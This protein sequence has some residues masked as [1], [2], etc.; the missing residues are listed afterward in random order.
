MPGSFVYA[1]A[2]GTVL[3]A[4]T[5]TLGVT[6][7]P[8]DTTLYTTATASTT[9]VVN[10]PRTTPTVSWATPAAITQGTAL[11][12]T[13]LNAT[14]SVPGSFVYAPAAGTVLTA[15]THTLGVTF[16]PTDTTRYT[17]A[18]AST[19]LVVNVPRTT[20]TVSWA[21]PAAITQGTALGA[22]QLNATASVPGSF[23]YAPAA[24]TVLT[25]GTHTLG[26]TFTPTDTTRYTTATASTTL[27]VN[28]P[29]TTPT[30][31]WATP[32]AI[33]QGT[34][35][36]A[37][38]LNATASVP[39]SFVYAPAAGTV[40]A[41]GT[42]TLGVTFTPTDAT[43]YTTATA[44]TTL[45]VNVPRTTP[46]V[47][48]A[49][50]AAI[51]QGTALSATQ[52][53]ATASVPG[54][55]VYA[56]AAGTVLTAG[57]HT[58]G[59]TFTPTDATRY[60]TATASTALVVNVPRTTPVLTWP[61]PASITQGTAL[62]A[63]Q[64]NATASVPGTFV[65]A[66]AAGTVL[67]AGTHT[68]GV[69]FTP[70]DATLYTTATASTTLV[71]TV[72]RTTPV[73][74]WPAPASITQGTA[75][76][77]TQLNATASV[78][79]TFVYAPAAGTVLAAGTHT[80]GVTFTPTDTTRY[81]AATASTTLVVTVPRTTPT[82]S[83]ATPAAITQGTALGAAQLNAT[84]S[85]PGSF[86]YAPA[87]GTVLA[88]GTHTLGVTFTPTDTTRY[89]TATASTTLVVNVPRT[90]PT[91]SWAT[92]AAITQ[93]TALGATQLNATASVPGT[94]VYAPAAGT[95][96]TAGTHTLGV[97]F[98]PTDTTLYT[99]ATASTTLVVNVPRTTPTVSWATPAAITQGTALGAAQLNATASVPGSFVY[100]P[101]AGTV[102]AAGTHTLGVTFTPTDA[103]RYT[104]ATASTTLVVNVP[105][106][107]PVLTWP[108]PVSITAGTPLSAT[109]L[110]A[111]ASVPGI[112]VYAPAAG[113]VLAAGTH[114]LG[115]TFT[116]TDA[117]RYTTA[118][119]STTLVV[120]VPRTT[121]VLT[122]PAPV[123]ITAGTPLS[124]T[125]LN[126][127]ASVPGSFVYAPAAGT[128]LPE[129][130]HTLQ[131]NF[132]PADATLYT[133]ATAST[134]L[135]VTAPRTTPTMWWRTPAAI[136]QGTALGATQLNATASVPGTFVYT[137]AAGT[138]LPAG[139]HT[140]RAAFTPANTTRYTTATAV[141]ALVVTVPR[142]TPTVSWATPA[143][144][145][146]GTALSA[147]QLNATA[148]VPGT[149]VYAP[150][151]GTVLAAGTHTLGVT[152]TPTDATLYT[153]ATA[154]T[155]LVVNVPRTTPTVSWA[156]PA[157]ITQGTALSATQLN[158]T[159]SVPGIFVYAPAAGTV[160][161][162]GTQTLAPRRHAHARGHLHADRHD[163]LHD[164]D[165]L[166]HPGGQ[167]AAHDADA[168]LGDAS[169]HHAGHR[170]QRDATERHGQRRRHLRLRARRRDRPRRRH[171]HARG[172]V[173]ADGHDAVHRGDRLDHAGGHR[174]AHHADGVVGD[175]GRH[176][177]GHR[178]RRG[179]AQRH[180]Q[181]SRKLRLRARRRYRAHGRHPYAGRYLH[182]DRRDAVHHGD[183]LDHP[184]GQRA[185][186]DASPHVARTGIDCAGH[187]PQRGA[188]E[189]H[190]QR[191]RHL[192]LR[193]R[194]RHRPHG[195]HPHARRHLHADRRDAVHHG[196]C[197][198]HAGGHRP[199]HDADGVLGDAGG[200]HAGHRAQRDAA[201]RHR[202][203]TG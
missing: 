55:F 122:W 196:D 179:A 31:S 193:A 112:F 157:A 37:A 36:G 88:A 42:H 118:T 106:T 10:V 1:P 71:V 170:A 45:V 129:G 110:N 8:T 108:A 15:G 167:R 151:A 198:D 153:T 96:L 199:A 84:A 62:S 43:R 61:A 121:P 39:G 138:V 107:T 132:T 197:L 4:G 200:H 160:L 104:T 102:L 165:C 7:T 143:A 147:A 73:L 105:R 82:V 174:P 93:G 11:G 169:G 66:P 166:Y 184:G 49:T 18:T 191:A 74:T 171:A 33:T 194:R 47:A 111:T 126:A 68:L 99:T 131:A 141:T 142:T 59:V 124:A 154:S 148:S 89:T 176:H 123:S 5:H 50:P 32:A 137:P 76:S 75:L 56:P 63:T 12:A 114:T 13:Q 17:T 173:H 115:V 81:T 29:R 79:G 201:E 188:A 77:A 145:T 158:A 162:A 9:L 161:A 70:T 41:A 19:T 181:R 116:P 190:G 202:Q 3:P 30:V 67:T 23:V 180:G 187:R 64:L 80:L 54:S 28:V 87:A 65:Y 139:T 130:T 46:T 117:T 40:L 2:A 20:P 164:G 38:Q 100:A 52:L 163:S 86:V 27:V 69:T 120:N 98:T 21:T 91:V 72:P 16:T 6:F 172:D 183:C 103:T 144:I 182:A 134:T 192:R 78:A 94:F 97:T 140:L 53:N 159:A 60:T 175:A 24:G 22:T 178:P 58:L 128:V 146:Q 186:H 195:R 35:L 177:A 92:P 136:T 133:T 127:T 95:V 152:F 135:V 125:Q 51:T 149:F 90:T 34:A 119:A 189:R 185:A 101:A 14:A 26:V 168:V 203:R 25:A 155:T 48:W 109:Q 156:T 85:V 113:T 150:A 44:S 57:T 83:W